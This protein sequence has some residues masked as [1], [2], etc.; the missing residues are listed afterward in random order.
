MST[1]LASPMVFLCR[2]KSHLS[3]RS[4]PPS[5]VLSPYSGLH[6]AFFSDINVA[7]VSVSTA[8]VSVSD[9]DADLICFDK[10]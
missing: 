2:H 7:F 8:F 1:S 9:V 3:H 6:A 5:S 4:P 10:L